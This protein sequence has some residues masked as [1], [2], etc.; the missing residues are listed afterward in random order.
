L[1]IRE[2]HIGLQKV[3]TNSPPPFPRFISFAP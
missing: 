2:D 3:C 1:H